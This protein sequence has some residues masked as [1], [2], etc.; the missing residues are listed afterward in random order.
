M[1]V[2]T[3]ITV[4]WPWLILILGLI[5][6]VFCYRPGLDGGF[7][8]DDY[9]NIVLNSA[10]SGA[11]WSFGS[12]LAASLSSDSGPL[13][14][15]LSMLSFA[16]QVPLSGLMPG[17]FK[18]VNLVIHLVNG[19]LVFLLCRQILPMAAGRQNR[20][21]SLFIVATLPVAVAAAWL[22]APINL[23]AVLYVVQRMESLAGLF[24]LLG[25]VAYLHGRG[26]LEAGRSGG[27]RWILAGLLGGTALAALA[28]ETGLLLS[29][30][31]FLLEWLLFRM[32]VAGAPGLDRRMLFI[33]GGVLFL[34]G[35][36]GVV[37]TLP[38]ALSGA[39]YASRP[40]TLDERLWTEGRV[41]LDY[42]HWII[43]PRLA[44]LGLFHDD[45]LLSRG[46]LTPLTTLPA[47]LALA[48]MLAAGWKV[49][50]RWPVVTLGV[51]FFFVGHGLVSTY[52]PLELV[53]EHRNYLPSIGVFLALFALSME[54][55]GPGLPRLG[56]LAL[57]SGVIALSGYTT[58]HRAVEWSDPIRLADAEARRH[59]GSPRALFEFG[60]ALSQRATTPDGVAFRLAIEAFERAGHLPG[61]GLY[62][63][64]GII[65]TRANQGLP[66]LDEHWRAI[67]EAIRNARLASQD[68]FAL[69]AL[70][71][72]CS[73]RDATCP[74]A[75]DRLATVLS[76]AVAHNPGNSDLRTLYASYAINIAR[77]VGLGLRLLQDAVALAPTRAEC[78]K[79]LVTMQ[80]STGQLAEAR[81]GLDNLRELNRFGTLDSMIESLENTLWGRLA[82]AGKASNSVRP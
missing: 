73:R 66:S 59:P 44:D 70:I 15:P 1:A 78:W 69:Q 40:F 63:W 52:L 3:L 79:N 28:K 10:V 5:G 53:Y 48:G 22:L 82:A 55:L 64:Q 34:P 18:V 58:Y 76:L 19:L 67:E 7:A 25:L 74:F 51:L 24:T 29:A 49:R 75:P 33:F 54:A 50:H 2:S 60:S 8:F 14:R 71:D 36:L 20:C 11:E 12:L 56:G 37:W 77:D 35:V 30:Y 27:W 39:A 45:Y 26:Q 6:T 47:I 17:P 72:A 62:P 68:V 57:V 41:V 42:L 21:P 16:L 23:T 13:A 38:S 61:S 81:V 32:R 31:A 46:W 65:L 4:R 9:P 80:I 43:A